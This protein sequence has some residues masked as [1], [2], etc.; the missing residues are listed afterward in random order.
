MGQA[1]CW[2]DVKGF[3]PLSLC[4][5][6]GRSCAVLFLGGCNLLCPTCHNPELA[7]RS[8]LLPAVD[9]VRVLGALLGRRQWL[10]GVTLSGGEPTDREGLAE[11]LAELR[12]TRLPLK[13]D[14]NGLYPEVLRQCLTL[15]LVDEIHVDIKGPVHLYP[16]LVG[17]PLEVEELR[18]RLTAVFDLAREFPGRFAFRTT[19][20][21]ALTPE[22]LEDVRRLVPAGCSH[23]LQPYV[24]PR[25]LHAPADS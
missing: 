5:W 9:R 2:S 24:P 19:M 11:L 6:P 7:H 23:R 1:S 3:T 12:A 4:D 13:L 14:T 10:D 18:A 22:H 25:S 20:V 15:G 21:P 17:M 16:L 8:H